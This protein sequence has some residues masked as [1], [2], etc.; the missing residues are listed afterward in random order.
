MEILILGNGGAINTGLHYNSFIING[1][2]LKNEF[3][4]NNDKIK[5]CKPGEII[6]I[7]IE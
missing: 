7:I 6:K 2:H 4:E 3:I 5:C 1:T